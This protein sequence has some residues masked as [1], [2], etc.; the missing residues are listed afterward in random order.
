MT[1]FSGKAYATPVPA[2]MP[3][4][5]IS[6]IHS[7]HTNID[8]SVSASVDFKVVFAISKKVA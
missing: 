2:L 4:F 8:T 1:P 7:V 3:D 6:P 5:D